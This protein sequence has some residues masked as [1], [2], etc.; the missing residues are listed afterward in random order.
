MS[1]KPRAPAVVGNTQARINRIGWGPRDIVCSSV[2][3]IGGIPSWHTTYL[4]D[5]N[6]MRQNPA[7]D[8]SEFQDFDA[9]HACIAT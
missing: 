7:L 6:A 5:A 9:V 2:H 3:A 4:T 1:P 8:T